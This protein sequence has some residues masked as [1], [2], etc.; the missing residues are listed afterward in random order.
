MS[1][2]P[3]Y[4]SYGP[5]DMDRFLLLFRHAF[6]STA[7][8]TRHYVETV[9]PEN[10]RVMRRNGSAVA[11]LGLAWVAQSSM[12]TSW[13]IGVDPGES[14]NLVTTG[15]FSQARNPIFTAMVAAQ[16]GTVLIAPSWPSLVALTALVVAVQLQVRRVEEPY[17]RKTHGAGYTEYSA[18]VGRFVPLIGRER[19]A[20]SGLGGR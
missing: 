9:G 6:A 18:Q 11:G 16:A 19:T 20:V 17:L 12:G 1:D 14:T 15:V 4:T 8:G 3:A 10:F 7:A 2:Q 13:R 5:S